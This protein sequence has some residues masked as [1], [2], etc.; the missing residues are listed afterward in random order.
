MTP[1]ALT[2]APIGAAE[3]A[4]LVPFFRI[5]Q[6]LHAAARADRFRESADPARETAFFEQWLARPDV[7]ARI[8]I[9]D[10]SDCGYVLYEFCRH[11]GGVVSHPRK[12]VFLH[13]IAV[14]PAH[15]RRGVGRAL[16]ARLKDHAREQGIAEMTSSHWAFNAAAAAFMAAIGLTPEVIRVG[17]AV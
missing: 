6:A 2:V 11:D 9:S 8:A 14:A 3:A 10:G 13:H 15:R 1:A 17:G 12:H 4:R 5:V 16:V 7:H